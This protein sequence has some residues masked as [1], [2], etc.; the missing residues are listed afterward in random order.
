MADAPVCAGEAIQPPDTGAETASMGIEKEIGRDIMN[1]NRLLAWLLCIAL[2]ILNCA[3]LAEEQGIEL[4]EE[5]AE[6]FPIEIG[7]EVGEDGLELD[8]LDG[9][10]V[11]LPDLELEDGLSG[12]PEADA[13]AN[14][15]VPRVR[16]LQFTGEALDND[17]LFEG[18]VDLLFGKHPQGDLRSNGLAGDN[19][20]GTAKKLYNNLVK[21]IKKVS[22]GS[23]SSTV[24]WIPTSIVDY[25]DYNTF[26]DVL[27]SVE[28]ALV[29][30]YPYELFWY[31]RFKYVW[32]GYNEQG[33]MYVM[34][35][36]ASEFADWSGYTY[37]GNSFETDTSKI[38]AAQSAA[39][40]A[41][42]VVSKNA[43]KSDYNKLCAYRDYIC[44]N[45]DYN[46]EAF[47][48]ESYPYIGPWQLIWVF[49]NDPYTKVVCEGYAKAFQYLCDLSSF[50]GDI[51]CYMIV[52]DA[53]TGGSS[54]LHAWNIVTMEDGR[55]Y[56]VDVTF[57][58]G[59]LNDFFLCGGK[60]TGRANEY[61]VYHYTYT[62]DAA[63]VRTFPAK[64][65]KL[66]TGDYEPGHTV[67]P[68]SVKLKKGKTTLKK[69]KKLDLKRGKSL[70]LKAVVSP[71]KAKTKLT[72]KSS[73]KYVT[74]KNGKVTVNK[75]A[76]VGAKAKITVKTAN[77]KS[78]Y[79]YIVVK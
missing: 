32:Y 3:A 73:Y 52:G 38:R 55:N 11:E 40:N 57:I 7:A 14:G 61:T 59:G 25:R 46:D 41:K 15:I 30:D 5:A 6:E 44:A 60:A 49:D 31:D 23:E 45:V 76:K 53:T 56:H 42:K 74:V 12:E 21:Q 69:G 75:K 72:W 33:M 67:E 2:L 26:G 22:T 16:Q 66:S 63:T 78:T 36:V 34:F 10:D 19:L 37:A 62:M 39:K 18:Y 8:G 35:T 71:G 70:T 68:K 24:F 64:R 47:E 65:L 58:D 13:E 54:G 9:L 4:I 28:Y 50:N 48:N 17:R 77:N 1:K 20:T 51:Q 43:G 27:V 79:I 29:V